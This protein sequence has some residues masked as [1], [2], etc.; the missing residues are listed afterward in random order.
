[1]AAAYQ[2]FTA[3]LSDS[4]LKWADPAGSMVKSPTRVSRSLE[5]D[6]WMGDGG[7]WV[8]DRSVGSLRWLWG[9][10]LPLSI[11]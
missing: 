7:K 10:C 3:E 5:W 4:I 11:E 8:V 2:K 1:M 6:G 9:T